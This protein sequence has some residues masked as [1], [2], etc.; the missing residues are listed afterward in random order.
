MSLV[1][2]RMYMR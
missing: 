1:M 2:L